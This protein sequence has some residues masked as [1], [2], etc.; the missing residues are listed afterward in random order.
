[1]LDGSIRFSDTYSHRPSNRQVTVTGSRKSYDGRMWMSLAFRTTLE[2]RSP[3]TTLVYPKRVTEYDAK[4][5]ILFCSL[6]VYSPSDHGIHLLRY[7]H[8]VRANRPLAVRQTLCI[9]LC[10]L[11]LRQ[12]EPKHVCIVLDT[13]RAVAFRQW[14]EPALQR[15]AHQ[16]LC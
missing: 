9:D 16:H 8:Q 5:G 14:D 1:M 2:T 4:V 3:T 13:I 12:L 7:R 10:H 15:P 11:V 6:P